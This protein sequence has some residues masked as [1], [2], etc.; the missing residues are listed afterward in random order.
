MGNAKA[1][2]QEHAR[3]FLEWSQN[4][5]AVAE[6]A[7]RRG[8]WDEAGEVATNS[9]QKCYDQQVDFGCYSGKGRMLTIGCVQI[10]NRI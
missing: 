2:R 4:S 3:K 9:Y 6:R 10:S 1:L 8:L 5:G 7:R